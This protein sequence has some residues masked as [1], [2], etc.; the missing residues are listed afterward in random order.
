MSVRRS[1]AKAPQAANVPRSAVLR[2]AIVRHSVVRAAAIVRRSVVKVAAIVRRSVVRVAAIDLRSVARVAAIAR[3]FVARA[4]VIVRRS[5]RPVV[6]DR[7]VAV[8]TSGRVQRVPFLRVR[9]VRV[10]VPV[11]GEGLVGE[12]IAHVVIVRVTIARV[13][14]G[15][16]VIAH[17]RALV[18]GLRDGRAVVPL[19]PEV[20]AKGPERRVQ[21]AAVRGGRRFAAPAAGGAALETVL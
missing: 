21:V 2:A 17:D 10:I 8:V 3:H 14:T 1:V 9:A 12:R 5:V 6:T 19:A 18:P 7:I 15:P 16:P 13:M 20:L 11:R 4:V